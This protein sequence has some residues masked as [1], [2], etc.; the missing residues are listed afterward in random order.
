MA[1]DRKGPYI[2]CIYNPIYVR[3]KSEIFV[4]RKKTFF[5]YWRGGGELVVEG[6]IR[7]IYEKLEKKIGGKGKIIYKMILQLPIRKLVNI[8]GTRSL[9]PFG[10]GWVQHRKELELKLRFF[11]FLFPLFLLVY[12]I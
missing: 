10:K 6:N 8:I 12:K 1:L 3:K 11:F 7:R 2:L 9:G 4:R 5:P